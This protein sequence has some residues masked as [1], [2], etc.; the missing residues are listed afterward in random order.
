[1]T[2]DAPAET[3]RM[4]EQSQANVTSSQDAA[5][6][7]LVVDL[8]HDAGTDETEDDSEPRHPYLSRAHS[9]I[10]ADTGGVFGWDYRLVSAI[11]IPEIPVG[12]SGWPQHR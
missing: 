11:G 3:E 5:G 10:G 12:S 9:A 2:Q 8:T 4:T 7:S 1:M 6:D